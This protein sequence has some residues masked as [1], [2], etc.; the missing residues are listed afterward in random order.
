VVLV[1]AL[2]SARA[3]AAE[4]V[5]GEPPRTFV[6]CFDPGNRLVLGVDLAGAG[7][8]LALRLGVGADDPSINWRLEH[9]MLDVRWIAADDEWRGALYRGRYHRHSRDGRLL[10]PTN[11]PK[12]IF[13]PFDVGGEVDA[14]AIAARRGDSSV[15]VGA[16][17][18]VFFFEL[19]RS[20]TFRR[21]L[22]L[23][24]VARW[25][26][27]VDAEVMS[28]EEHRVAPFSM[29]L[30]AFHQESR[31]GLWTL[32]ASVEAG[33]RWSS[34][35]GWQRTAIVHGDVE[36]VLVAVN[37]TPVSAFVAGGYE[38]AGQGAWVTAGVRVGFGAAARP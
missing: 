20:S 6:T 27:V 15:E 13:L 26:I 19:T 38:S 21:R 10:L 4:C 33:T 2:A 7:G 23:G 34:V 31:D 29:G 3:R 24:P 11:P 35:G 25:D 30:L 28:A 8:A 1:V 37:D 22:V 16:V 18:V 9:V 12:K 5:G 14:L 36:R 17:R 32:D